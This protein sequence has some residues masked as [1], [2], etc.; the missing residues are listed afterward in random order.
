MYIL[1]V[2][3]LPAPHALALRIQIYYL[4]ESDWFNLSLVVEL[5]QFE[6]KVMIRL[7]LSNIYIRNQWACPPATGSDQVGLWENTVTSHGI[8]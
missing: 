2:S 7:R 5:S 6:L 4:K 1:H 8:C 3:A